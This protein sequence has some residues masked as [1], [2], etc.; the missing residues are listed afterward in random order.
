MSGSGTGIHT[1]YNEARGLTYSV[2]NTYR[3]AVD[4]VGNADG[5]QGTVSVWFTIDGG[6]GTWRFLLR[7]T[8]GGGSVTVLLTNANAFLVLMET[9]L[10][11]TALELQTNANSYMANAG[12]WQHLVCS[13]DLSVPTAAL[14][15]NGVT[16]ALAINTVN[17]ATIDYTLT[18][19]R[20][21]E[22]TTNIH[23]WIGSL[24]ALYF[25]VV[26][27]IDLSVA[28]NRELF[29]HPN[30]QPA[31]LWADGSGPTGAQPIMYMV[32]VG[33]ALVNRGTGGAFVVNGAPPIS[34]TSP[35]G[36]WV[37]SLNHWQRKRKAAA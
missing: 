12:V 23:E 33:G 5:Q 16:P 14:Y 24:S 21:G 36:R 13:W 15:I 6:N 8:G 19:W 35:R 3:R 34:A 11:A 9:A 1:P 22:N 37:A 20:V 4:L 7:A 28:A 27:Y 30:G 31:G 17:A 18:T 26:G 2:G 25:N 10:A 32:E 29:V